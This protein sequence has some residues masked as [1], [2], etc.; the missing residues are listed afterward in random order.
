MN[1]VWCP[2]IYCGGFAGG[3]EPGAAGAPPGA[4]A[5]PGG[6]G[7]VPA[8]LASFSVIMPIVQPGELSRIRSRPFIAREY[9]ALSSAPKQMTGGPCVSSAASCTPLSFALDA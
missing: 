9:F 6:V 5:A 1:Y 8:A 2:R 3:G 4:G 7:S